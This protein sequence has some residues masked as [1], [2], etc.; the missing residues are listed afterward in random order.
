MSACWKECNDFFIYAFYSLIF[1]TA[2]IRG[3][4]QQH[5]TGIFQ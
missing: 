4:Q 2:H 3:G 5:E 1:F